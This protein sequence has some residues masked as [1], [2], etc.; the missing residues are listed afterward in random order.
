MQSQAQE[1]SEGYI[2]CLICTIRYSILTKENL[3]LLWC[4]HHY[5]PCT[6]PDYLSGLDLG[7]QMEKKKSET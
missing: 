6:Q 5:V 7:K 1:I 2:K 4:L 3:N